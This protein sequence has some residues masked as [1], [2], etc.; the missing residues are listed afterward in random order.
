M[1]DGREERGK[2]EKSNI[3]L[4]KQVL[5]GIDH[6]IECLVGLFL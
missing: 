2:K 6:G 3:C 5:L 1:K 4:A